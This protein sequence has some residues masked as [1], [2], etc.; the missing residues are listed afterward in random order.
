MGSAFLMGQSGID[1]SDATALA[2]DIGEGKTAYLADGNKATGT[3]KLAT[4]YESGSKSGVN[5][6]SATITLAKKPL[7]IYFFIINSSGSSKFPGYYNFVNGVGDIFDGTYSSP[8]FRT[9]TA[10]WN[11]AAKELTLTIAAGWSASGNLYWRVLE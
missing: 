1:T 10:S 9:V 11:D 8:T 5:M 6:G 7:F 4:T 3:G 2:S